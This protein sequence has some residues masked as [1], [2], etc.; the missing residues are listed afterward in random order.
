MSGC[1]GL[2]YTELVCGST[3]Q[4]CVASILSPLYPSCILYFCVM[5]MQHSVPVCSLLSLIH[6]PHVRAAPIVCRLLRPWEH[7]I[8]ITM[9]QT[10]A[11]DNYTA[12]LT[13][14]MT[15]HMSRYWPLFCFCY[16]ESHNGDRV[17][18][19]AHSHRFI[20]SSFSKKMFI[21]SL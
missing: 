13:Q 10:G 1:H 20:I 18:P 6:N 19:I 16:A 4:N 21:K 17:L 8:V 9:L 7:Y 2:I 11:R 12:A 3:W 5:A 14:P 15:H